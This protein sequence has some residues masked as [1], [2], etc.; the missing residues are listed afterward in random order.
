MQENVTKAI[1]VCDRKTQLSQSDKQKLVDV[2]VWLI[3]EDKKQNPA[4]YQRK[5]SKND[6]HCMPSNT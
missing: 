4:L 2:F 3:K 1:K 5:I 6:R